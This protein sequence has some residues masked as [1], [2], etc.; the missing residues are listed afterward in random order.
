VPEDAHPMI[1]LLFCKWSRHTRK[2]NNETA[3]W[4]L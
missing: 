2:T 3:Y 4:V 1:C